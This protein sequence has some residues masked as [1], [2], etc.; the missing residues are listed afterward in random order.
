M[1]NKISVALIMLGC[2]LCVENLVAQETGSTRPALYLAVKLVDGSYIVGENVKEKIN[3]HSALLGDFKLEMKDIRSVACLSS[4]SASLTTTAGDQLTVSWLDSRLA[5]KTSFGKVELPV[6]AIS[7]F[8]VQAGSSLASLHSGLVAQWSGDNEGKDTAGGHDAIVSKSVAYLPAQ[9]GLGFYFDGQPNKI[10]VPDAPELNFGAGQDFSIEGWVKPLA[11]PPYLRDGIMSFVD[12]R[13]IS[14]NVQSQGYEFNLVE[15]RIHCRLSDSITGNGGEW[16]PAGFD[17]RDGK[18]H[19]IA[20]TVV[21]NS[22][23]GGRMFVDG[24]IVLTFDPTAVSGDLSND[25]ALLIGNHPDPNY[26]C[27]FHGVIGSVA[28]YKRALSPDEIKFI[29]TSENNGEGK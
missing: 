14:N 2:L 9:T 27:F 3:F 10:I 7:K 24:Q 17:L 26:R 21:R 6:G 16:G 22:P 15:G 18:F 13:D 4:N 1:K 20:L 8:T 5:V 25:N 28:I 23:D 19:H 12:K 11:P 29:F